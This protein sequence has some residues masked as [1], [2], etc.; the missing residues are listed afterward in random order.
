L[1]VVWLRYWG[2]CR[3]VSC[4][5]L[6]RSSKSGEMDIMTAL[7]GIFNFLVAIGTITMAILL[8]FLLG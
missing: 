2:V 8:G 4:F 1:A 6:G 7:T 5:P 3:G